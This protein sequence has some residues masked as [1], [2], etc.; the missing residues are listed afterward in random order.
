MGEYAILD[1]SSKEVIETRFY[2]ALPKSKVGR[3]MP[4]LIGEIPKYDNINEKIVFDKYEILSGF[5]IKQWKIVPSEVPPTITNSQARDAL[6]LRGL[7]PHQVFSMITGIQDPL[8]KQ[9]ALNKWEYGNQLERNHPVLNAL[10]PL[11]NLSQSDIDQI[12]REG[13]NL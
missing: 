5:V 2:E 10:A 7:S 3:I 11:M 9:L 13:K 8:E 12:F 1:V 6:T 4:V